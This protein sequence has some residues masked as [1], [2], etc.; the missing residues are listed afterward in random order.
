M[1]VL[2]TGGLI[3]VA[4]WIAAWGQF[5]TLSEYSFF[6]LWL[7]Y[8]LTTNGISQV[9][10]GTSLLARMKR[11]FMWLFA[12]SMPMWWFFERVN[13][14]VQNWHYKTN[15]ISDIHF[16][17][18][19]SIDFSTIIPAVL[20]TSFL[21]HLLLLRKGIFLNRPPIRVR[22][23]LLWLS[24]LAGILSFSLVIHFPREAFP[25][26]WIAPVFIIE[27]VAYALGLPCMLRTLESGRYL[28]PVS[29]MI[30]TL[31]TGL[32]WE[33]W[34]YYSFPKWYYTIPYGDFLK[35]FE[36]PFL[37]YFAYP[38]FGL[39]IFGYASISSALVKVPIFSLFADGPF[40]LSHRPARYYRQQPRHGSSHCGQKKDTQ[41]T[42][43]GNAE[44]GEQGNIH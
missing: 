25:L 39:I 37:G 6:P 35:I 2:V 17:V 28:G 8:I 10:F 24:I 19:A 43:Q 20:S 29:T 23:G 30:A 7:G 34:N 12:I 31:F 4:S 5:G 27:P 9:S 14:I 21:F 40:R 11:S 42:E 44:K 16:F 18:Q 15:P 33:L 26:V 3:T 41:R 32:W 22:K 38:F 36:L 13:K 1:P